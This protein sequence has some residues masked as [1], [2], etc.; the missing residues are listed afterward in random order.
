MSAIQSRSTR[1][2]IHELGPWFHNLHLPD[3][4]Q[5]AP[6]HEYGDFPAFKWRQIEPFIPQD[7]DGATVLDIGCNAGFYSFELARR[8]AKVTAIDVDPHYLAQARWAARQF[9]LADRVSFRQMQIYDIT[10]LPGK[11][12][13]IWL[14]GVLYHLRH[15]LLALDIV[16]SKAADRMILQTMTMPGDEILETPPDLGLGERQALRTTGWPHMA[17]IENRL[18][19]DPTNWWAPNAAC[20]LAMARSAGFE[21]EQQLTHETWLCRANGE[22]DAIT[23]RELGSIVRGRT[24]LGGR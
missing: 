15:P 5:T 14:M 13:W 4:E 19:G 23:L 18:A 9:D 21:V 10:E 2:A 11:F 12:D 1:Q 6:E 3:G 16:R 22:P 7:L 17:F 8:G 24:P 20:V